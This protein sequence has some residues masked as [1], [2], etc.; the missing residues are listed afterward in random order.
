MSVLALRISVAVIR[1]ARMWWTIDQIWMLCVWNLLLYLE[2]QWRDW[3]WIFVVLTYI[4]FSDPFCICYWNTK[5]S[6]GLLINS[7]HTFCAS[8]SL[9]YVRLKILFCAVDHWIPGMAWAIIDSCKG[10]TYMQRSNFHQVILIFQ[11]VN[12]GTFM[13]PC[14]VPHA[15]D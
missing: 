15:A 6:L 13:E 4:R 7:S 14:Q 8:S 1:I 5:Y 3:C 2:Y 9:Y 11:S 12:S 10:Q